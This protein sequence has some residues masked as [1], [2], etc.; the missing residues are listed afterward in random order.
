MLL[1]AC[2]NL[3]SGPF[4]F[5]PS[6]GPWKLNQ[7]RE[8]AAGSAPERIRRLGL[9][10]AQ[11][12]EYEGP[13]SI[14]VEAYELTSSAA[15]FEAEQQWRPLAD[16]VVFHRERYFLIIHWVNAPRDAVTAFVRDMENQAGR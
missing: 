8:I 10:S 9:K 1:A 13:G 11:A 2:A 6:A 7:K 15:A 3:R 12:A 16:A 4:V 5:P 14:A